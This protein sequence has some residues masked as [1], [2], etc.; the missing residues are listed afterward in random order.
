MSDELALARPTSLCGR[1]G[2]LHGAPT[3]PRSQTA[4]RLPQ[5]ALHHRQLIVLRTASTAGIMETVAV[6]GPSSA[7]GSVATDLPPLTASERR[8]Y[9]KLAVGMVRNDPDDHPLMSQNRF[10]EHFRREFNE[11]A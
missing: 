9:D 6:A 3:I 5:V 11:S 10:H 7:S 8:I 1:I 4:V 2:R